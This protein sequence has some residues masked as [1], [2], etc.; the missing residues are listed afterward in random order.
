MTETPDN[1]TRAAVAHQTMKQYAEAKNDGLP[2]ESAGCEETL[3]DLLTDLRHWAKS[4]EEVDFAKADRLAAMNYSEESGDDDGDLPEPPPWHNE[5]HRL[6][7]ETTVE[8]DLLAACRAVLKIAG[9]N[10]LP[11]NG[12]YSGAA[13]TD[14]VWAAVA[15]AEGRGGA[16]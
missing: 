2:L 15:R 13:I 16:R 11:D 10:D 1:A 6:A 4:E 8:E 3:V 12:E 14:Q 9:D 5:S 7:G